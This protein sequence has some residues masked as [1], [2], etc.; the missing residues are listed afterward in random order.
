MR[1]IQ[2]KV[3]RSLIVLAF[4]FA[5]SIIAVQAQ[6]FTVFHYFK[7]F[8]HDGNLPHA[9]LILDP[10]GNLYGTTER[11]GAYGA[12][13]VY[14]LDPQGNV[15]LLHSFTGTGDGAYPI[16]G[17]VRDSAGNLYGTTTQRGDLTCDNS[18]GCGTIFKIDATGKFG[19]MHRFH[20]SEGTQ[21]QASLIL[22]KAGNLYGTAPYLGDST[23]KCGTVF[24]LD[25]KGKFTVLHRFTNDPDGSNPFGSLARD[26]AGNLYGT[27]YLGGNPACDYFGT[28][29]GTIFK[30]AA[31]G[32]ESVLHSFTYE[33]GALPESGLVLDASGNLYG[34]ANTGGTSVCTICGTIF[35]LDMGGQLTTLHS[36]GQQAPDGEFPG[37]GTLVLDAAGNLYGTTYAGGGTACP[38]GATE[39][40]GAV[41]KLD[42]SGNL[43]QLHG[44]KGG[45]DGSQPF[46]SL[47]QDSAGSLYGT[48][49]LGGVFPARCH[50]G[51]GA[52][53]KI[54]P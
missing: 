32:T 18:T 14:K 38:N 19:V 52:V 35:K 45:T 34:T 44:F 43:T 16:G 24:K 27:T 25:T 26:A 37:N 51:C 4:T 21:V 40:C 53:F 42:S 29:C 3:M 48:T 39:G 47:V 30:I 49:S 5:V 2:F 41:F 15:T 17:L 6:T 12:G 1:K 22:D 9:G 46:G 31:N 54:T 7:G 11:A 20:T 8:P 10:A 28:S 36:F 13:V 33:D 50:Y 23:C